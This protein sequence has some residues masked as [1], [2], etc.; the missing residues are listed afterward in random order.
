ME[1][2]ILAS[3]SINRQKIMKVLGIPFKVVVSQFDES[4][5]EEI[6]QAIRARKIAI[7]KAQAVASNHRRRKYSLENFMRKN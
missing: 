7:G 4:S 6:N 1:Q 3:G 2:L 5:I